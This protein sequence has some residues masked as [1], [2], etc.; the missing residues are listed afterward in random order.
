ME[1][2]LSSNCNKY[3]SR[4][5]V[6]PTLKAVLSVLL[7]TVHYNLLHTSV[8]V[9]TIKVLPTDQTLGQKILC[10]HKGCVC[11]TKCK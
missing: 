4:G 11:V 3:N 1:Q 9:F 5:S 8:D 7:Q 6:D 2:S 10:V